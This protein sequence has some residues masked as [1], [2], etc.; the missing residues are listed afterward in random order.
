MTGGMLEL[1]GLGSLLN[2]LPPEVGQVMSMIKEAESRDDDEASQHPCARE[3]NACI[4]ETGSDSRS[5]IEGCL[6]KHYTALSSDCKCFVHHITNGRVP[7]AAPSSSPAAVRI[8]ASSAPE[9]VLIRTVSFSPS[10][11]KMPVEVVDDLKASPQP[12]HRISCLF[13]FL[14]LTIFTFLIVRAVVSLLCRGP[15]S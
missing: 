7:T 2:M 10:V 6:V 15:R 8:S 3:I 14:A 11:K 12:V 4:R 1:P 9:P 5:A 13:V